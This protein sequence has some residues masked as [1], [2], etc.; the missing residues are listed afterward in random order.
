MAN[1]KQTGSFTDTYTYT[2]ET[3][4]TIVVPRIITQS[5]QI[6]HYFTEDLEE[7]VRL[8]HT[9]LAKVLQ[10][11]PEYPQDTGDIILMLYE[12][13]AHMLR[14]QLIIGV[15][16]LLSEMHPDPNTGAYPLRYHAR[17]SIT[18]DNNIYP[19]AP[20]TSTTA[21]RTGK[22][23]AP[24]TNIWREARFALLIDWNPS[25]KERRQKVRRPEY[26][27]DWVPEEARFDATNLVRYS[28]GG[29]LSDSARVD[30]ETVIR[31]ELTSPAYQK[32]Q[33]L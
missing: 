16:L 12:D 14:D 27:F 15:H 3:V 18:P 23:I 5:D 31:E 26:C 4:E 32:Q 13:I 17:Y 29:M 1:P 19:L 9:D 28:K 21:Q 33:P 11:P 2:K 24:P 10:I 8:S 22:S 30:S 6:A 20:S 25:A 7:F